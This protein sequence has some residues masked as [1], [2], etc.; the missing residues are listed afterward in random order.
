MHMHKYMPHAIG[1]FGSVSEIMTGTYMYMCMY[2]YVHTY[3]HRY[4]TQFCVFGASVS[5]HHTYDFNARFSLYVVYIYISYGR[6]YICD[7]HCTSNIA[8]NISIFHLGLIRGARAYILPRHGAAR[9][10]RP[11]PLLKPLPTGAEL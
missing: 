1:I 5:E 3:N 6:I 10:G 4:N 9:S 7:R 8:I 2:M 11:H